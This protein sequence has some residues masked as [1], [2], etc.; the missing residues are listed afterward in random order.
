MKRLTL[1]PAA[2]ALLMTA[3]VLAACNG[4]DGGA[5]GPAQPSPTDAPTLATPFQGSREPIEVRPESPET[6]FLA[7]VRTA[8]QEGFDRVVFEF[9]GGNT[10]YLIE[11]VEPPIKED[12]SDLPVDIEG[13][14]FLRVVFLSGTAVDLMG[15][16]PRITC[17]ASEFA[18]GLPALVDLQ[19][20]GDFE[21][22]MTWVFGLSEEVD[23]G[24][25]EL[26]DPYRIV[27]DVAHP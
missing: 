16:E 7:D 14:A 20:T 9:D 5:S 25:S 1:A 11:Y 24:V 4:G 19:N 10:G 13:N 3:T 15:D 2:T 8:E 12:P 17:C 26:Q 23:F 27:I 21:A 6:A 22:T 18:T